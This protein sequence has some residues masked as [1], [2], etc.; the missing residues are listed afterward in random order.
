MLTNEIPLLPLPRVKVKRWALKKPF[1]PLSPLDVKDFLTYRKYRIP[2]D[3]KTKKP[4]TGKD[5]LKTLAIAHPTDDILGRILQARGLSKAAGYMQEKHVGPDGKYHPT[6]TFAPDTGRLSAI[7]P[8]I[9]N[10]PNHGV[11]QEVVEAIR[12]TIIPSKP[13]HLLVEVDWRAIEA[14]LT[15]FFAGDRAFI[16]LSLVDSHSFLGWAIARA[17]GEDLP[18]L[19]AEDPDL[20]AKL[21]W[22]KKTHSE[23]RELAKRVNHASSYGMGARLMAFTLSCSIAEAKALMAIKDAAAPLVTAWKKSTLWRAH[24][25]GF[26]E[27]PFAYRRYYTHVL[28]PVETPEGMKLSRGEEANKALAFLPQ[29]TAAG[30]MR[31]VLRPVWEASKVHAFSLI[32]TIHD[33]V[34]LEVEENAVERVVKIV[35]GIMERPWVEL[36]GLAIPTEAKAGRRWSEMEVVG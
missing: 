4:T 32:A 6:F 36:D 15:G 2:L 31:L 17:R 11:D 35:K 29:S 8:N 16:K 23:L 5:A 33:A 1:S 14:V 18:E 9:Q 20:T 28:A 21:K 12:R 34:L 22:F 26:L 24:K 13:G 3:R 25:E 7:A 30:M 10:Q 19:D 27:N